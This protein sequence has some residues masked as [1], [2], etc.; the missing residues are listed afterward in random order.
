[1]SVKIRLQRHGRK[2]KPFFWIV[3]ADSRSK[4]DGRS[5]EKIGTYDPNTNPATIELDIDGAVNWL[6]NGAQPT[7]TAR[8]ILSYKGA[9]LK[10]HLVGG[11]KKGALTE[12]QAESKYQAWLEEKA[13][14]VSDK[15][16]K[17]AKAEEDAKTAILDAEKAVNAS[18]KEAA[19]AIVNE[20]IKVKADAKAAAEAAAK[21]K[22]AVVEEAPQTIDDVAKEAKEE[23]K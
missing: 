21:A 19:D 14:K 23:E 20:A 2:G 15:E 9:L 1:M 18:R 10:N 12:E 22:E 13:T 7:D 11:V 6:Q 16:G 3:A 8:A 17:L 4:R 5:L